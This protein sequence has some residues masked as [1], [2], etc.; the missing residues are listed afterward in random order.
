[1][2][3]PLNTVR[4]SFILK[5]VADYLGLRGQRATPARPATETGAE[6]GP[7]YGVSTNQGLSPLTLSELAADFGAKRGIR[8]PAAVKAGDN[9]VS[10]G[11]RGE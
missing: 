9:L 2:E 1:M 3:P 4:P 11:R 5:R 10:G 7:F 6:S 8:P